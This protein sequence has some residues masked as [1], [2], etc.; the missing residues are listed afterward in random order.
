MNTGCPFQKLWCA[1]QSILG[2]GRPLRDCVPSYDFNVYPS[3]KVKERLN[4]M[5]ANPVIRGS[6]QHP[7]DWPSVLSTRRPLLTTHYSLLT[8]Q[9]ERTQTQDPPSKTENEAPS[10]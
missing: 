8:D 6:V 3:G 2:R 7:K 4:Y 10:A 9:L 1:D 5:H